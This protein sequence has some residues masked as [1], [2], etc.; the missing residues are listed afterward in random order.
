MKMKKQ[1]R[2]NSCK[3][4]KKVI[5]CAAVLSA[6]GL[7]PLS[8]APGNGNGAL[9]ADSADILDKYTQGMQYQSDENYYTAS[10]YYL[11]ITTQNPAFT[12]AWYRLAECSYKLGEFD[13]ALQYLENAQK[14][15]KDN[16]KIQN[17][18]GMVLV[19]LGQ[20]D[21]G[22]D[23]FN[24]IL[25]KYPNDIDAR[26]GLAEI[27]L[28]EGRFSGAQN[29]YIEALK[30]QNTNRK[31]L[32]SLAIVNAERGQ[33]EEAQ[34]YLRRALSY[35]SGEPEV[36]YIASVI[37][38]MAGD[39]VTAEKQARIAVEVNSNYE[40]AYDMLASVLYKQGRYKEVIDISDYLISRNRKNTN[41]W[42]I[43]GVAQTKTGNVSAAI[44]TWSAA[45]NINPQDE[46][47]RS[48]L[49]NEV[50]SLLSLEDS[51]RGSYAKY[52]IENAKQYAT[53]YDGA[54]SVYEYQRALLLDPLN[55]EA[56]SA[57][58]DIL[59]INGMY[60]LYLE[61]LKFL[62]EN[63][64][65]KNTAL[66]DKIEAYDDLL[67][68]TLGKKW[69]VNP[70]YLDKTR[71]N[72]AVF[73]EEN[74]SSFVHADINR[75]VANAAADIFSG[76]AITSVKTQVTPV[77]GYGEAF[78]NARAGGFDYF[79]ILSLS[80]GSNDMTLNSTI[81]SGRTGLEV[82]KNSFYSTGN[83]R[84]STVLRRFRAS[85]L[86]K[87]TVRGK[88]LARNGKLVLVDLGKAENIQK[89]AQFKIIKKGQIR[90]AD[91]GAGLY[92]RDDDVLGTITITLAG[93]EISEGNIENHGFYDR[94]NIDDEVVLVAIPG[95]QDTAAVA[96]EAVDTVPAADEKGKT[97][98]KK[99]VKGEQ[100]VEEIKKA[101]ERPSILDLLR[102]IY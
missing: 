43:K 58:A 9:S 99:K 73:Y 64:T 5:L 59:E 83:N 13:L 19:S 14:Y 1:N 39:F 102:N 42:F 91:S 78:R 66:D 86:E 67:S 28:Y 22:R 72:I 34:N 33:A 82:G 68:N 7:C 16:T 20:T 2:N 38:S 74:N 4:L 37:Y 56:R 70:F 30:R 6:A 57:Y 97:L 101:V 47:M 63:S 81:Y 51:R 49:E 80:E 15:E 25:K 3:S 40:K 88:I 26:F 71:W 90:T 96:N 93:E 27:E 45:L 32:L 95:E 92:Y 21:K 17:L 65:G 79:V 100:I 76:V 36:H 89:D 60:E 98:F 62:K 87:L 53:R 29:Q 48:A 10:Q 35:Y 11:E 94:I 24:S 31:A 54:G 85:V 52:H 18:K 75:L 12:D 84:F 44:D 41:A 55:Y 46:I 8:A 50:R 69:G 61:Q 23:I 77:S